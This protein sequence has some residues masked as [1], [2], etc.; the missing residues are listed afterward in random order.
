MRR[1][2]R[3]IW[4]TG[5]LI[6]GGCQNEIPGSSDCT[7][8]YL[9]LGASASNRIDLLLE[10]DSN[11]VKRIVRDDGEED[12]AAI[13]YR[14]D[15]PELSAILHELD[16]END[17]SVDS[18]MERTQRLLNR[19]DLYQVDAIADDGLVDS[20]QI[21]IPL[22]T[23]GRFGAWRPARMF[24]TIPCGPSH[25]IFASEDGDTVTLDIDLNQDGDLDGRM[26]IVFDGEA[27]QSWVVDND[28]DGIIDFRGRTEYREDGR[29]DNV[30]WRD[31]EFAPVAV[32]SFAYDA[33]GRLVEFN[34]DMSG[35]GTVENQLIYAAACWEDTLD[36][37]Q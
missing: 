29:I 8:E 21:S 37:P 10:L 15:A 17:G 9:R 18:T 2:P 24:Y 5:A 22:E 34:E 27:V 26:E 28:R 30:E 3:M 23:G 20:L 1:H 4:L 6:L 19:I 31:W 13:F 16:D 11:Q 7:I 25:Q 32:A 33:Q 12:S 14:F 35:N 36:A